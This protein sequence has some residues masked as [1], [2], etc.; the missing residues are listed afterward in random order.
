MTRNT[1]SRFSHCVL[2]AGVLLGLSA[3]NK[4]PTSPSSNANLIVNL[5]DDHTGDVKEVNLFFTSVTANP[6]DGP[7]EVLVLELDNNP[8]DLLVLQD[9]VI[10]LATGVVDPGDYA[11]VTINLDQESSNILLKTGEVVPLRIPSEKIKILGGFT[12]TEDGLTTVTL[13][14]VAEESLVL[15]GNGEWLLQPVILMEVSNS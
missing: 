7:P 14:F 8:Q 1:A 5:T 6:T 2:I 3:C 10:A 13:D 9:M 12:V 11:S 4:A 15:L